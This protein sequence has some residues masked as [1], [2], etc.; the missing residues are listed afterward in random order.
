MAKEY[1]ELIVGDWSGDGHGKHD[2]FPMI[3][4]YDDENNVTNVLKEAEETIKK[5]FDIDLS[6][7]FSDYED[8]KI[9][10]KDTQKL[11][12][13]GININ[14]QDIDNGELTVWLAEDFFEIWKQLIVK[15]NP[16]IKIEKFVF[17]PFDSKCSGYG[18]Y[19]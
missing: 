8:N 16:K 1:V 13:L 11:I 7:W 2:S 17:T 18:L 14:K 4:E 3:I 5:Q 12:D 10:K 19:E 15:V 6:T 9:N